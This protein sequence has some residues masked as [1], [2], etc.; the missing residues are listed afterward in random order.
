[1]VQILPRS[2][3]NAALLVLLVLVL[4]FCWTVRSVLNPLLFGYL[5][6]YILLP[7]VERVERRLGSRRVAVNLIFVAGFVLTSLVLVLL[8]WQL[9]ALALDVYAS[10]KLDAVP[11][12]ASPSAPL[13]EQLQRR[14]DEFTATLTGW[15]LTVPRWEVPDLEV[16]R[17][18]A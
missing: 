16:L 3:R 10:V 12:G 15:G 7:L 4:W 17:A 9:R 11:P 13:H 5:L 18:W 1:M 2:R 14:A 8:A 6:A